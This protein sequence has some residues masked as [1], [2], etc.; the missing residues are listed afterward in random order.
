MK[1]VAPTGGGTR[2]LDA[3]SRICWGSFI[4]TEYTEEWIESIVDE[5]TP[6]EYTEGRVPKDEYL[7]K[8]IK[9][10]RCRKEYRG[11]AA[12]SSALPRQSRRSAVS[13]L[14]INEKA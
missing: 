14:F 10:M 4:P 8:E 5:N 13:D 7:G 2:A 9:K 11:N 3:A 6:T 12:K 1:N